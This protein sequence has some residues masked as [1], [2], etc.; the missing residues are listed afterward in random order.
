MSTDLI[1]VITSL[2]VRF[3]PQDSLHNLE[4]VLADPLL[5]ALFRGALAGSVVHYRPTHTD[6]HPEFKYG[7]FGYRLNETIADG[8]W[9]DLQRIAQIVHCAANDYNPFTASA[10]LS[11]DLPYDALNE[12]NLSIPAVS[13]TLVYD[14]NPLLAIVESRDKVIERVQ[15]L[16]TI[17]FYFIN[18]MAEAVRRSVQKGRDSAW[19]FGAYWGMSKEEFVYRA[20]KGYNGGD[21][22]KLEDA[23]RKNE[24]TYDV[25]LASLIKEDSDGLVLRMDNGKDH[26]IRIAHPIVLPIDDCLEKLGNM[27]LN[28]GDRG[29]L[30][31][32]STFGNTDDTSFLII[33][34]ADKD[35]SL[36]PLL[37]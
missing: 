7:Q 13:L 30:S 25:P 26:E 37:I 27:S 23:V 8:I 11:I 33:A 15:I 35:R 28:D 17:G 32:D 21:F 9:T 18:W 22:D 4:T 36:S 10:P 24:D 6:V 1:E 19:N 20:R 34:G 29:Y 12:I 2:S 16:K 14:V 5:K 3:N 31:E